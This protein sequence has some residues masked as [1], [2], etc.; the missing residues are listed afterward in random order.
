MFSQL[1]LKTALKLAILELLNGNVGHAAEVFVQETVK[2]GIA[3]L[4]A[5]PGCFVLAV[6]IVAATT[7][8]RL[9]LF[10]KFPGVYRFAWLNLVNFHAT[11]FGSL[12]VC[13]GLL[14]EVIKNG[15][16]SFGHLEEG[17]SLVEG[18]A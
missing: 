17:F 11:L 7:L 5:H 18:P 13:G 1:R 2:G 15:L 9:N 14:F 16:A 8:Q 10:L 12:D 3:L 6:E 4:H